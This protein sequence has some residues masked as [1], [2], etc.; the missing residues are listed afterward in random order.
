MAI[1]EICPDCGGDLE[2]LPNGATICI[3]G[4]KEEPSIQLKEKL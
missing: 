3:C 4:H 2:V 1:I